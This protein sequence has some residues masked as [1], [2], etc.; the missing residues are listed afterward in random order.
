MMLEFLPMDSLVNR[1]L[2]D[3]PDN[4]WGFIEHRLVDILDSMNYLIWLTL[5][6]N[7]DRKKNGR[8]P[9]APKPIVR[10]GKVEEKPKMGSARDLARML[11]GIQ[12]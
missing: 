12:G 4:D 7:W 1:K 11:R 6:S 10:P 5:C 3:R 8:P 9:K 2:A